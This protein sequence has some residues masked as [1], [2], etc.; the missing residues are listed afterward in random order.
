MD[1][2]RKWREET[3]TCRKSKI[4]LV[5]WIEIHRSRGGDSRLCVKQNSPSNSQSFRTQRKA[6]QGKSKMQDTK[7]AIPAQR[8][9][10]KHTQSINQY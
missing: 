8:S 6:L 10:M 2:K 7:I 4:A 3:K 9:S 5:D 1:G